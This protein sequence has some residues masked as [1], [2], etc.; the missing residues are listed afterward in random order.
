MK[1]NAGNIKKGDFVLYRDKVWQ[2]SKTDFSF[3]G[4][5][6]AVVRLKFKN[7]GDKATIDQTFKS[8]EQLE[9]ADVSNKPMQYLYQDGKNLFFMDEASFSQ[10]SLP[11]DS[12]GK[13]ANFLKSGERYQVVVYDEKPLTIRMPTLVKLKVTETEAAAK[14]DTVS[15]AKKPAKVETGVTI[16]VPLFIKA[17]DTIIVNPETGAYVERAK[18]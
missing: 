3:H 2:I 8:T 16:T 10:L 11:Q 7:T 12:V 6:L 13:L 15:G 9:K 1:V 14:G 4:R 18:I 17:G 5:G